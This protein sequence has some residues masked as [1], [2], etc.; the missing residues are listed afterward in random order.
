MGQSWTRK[1]H[2]KIT[3]QFWVKC[4]IGLKWS[5]WLLLLFH[6]WYFLYVYIF[7]IQHVLLKWLLF[8]QHF[9]ILNSFPPLMGYTGQGTFLLS[10]QQRDVDSLSPFP[11][12]TRSWAQGNLTSMPT[13]PY[14]FL[15]KAPPLPRPP[16]SQSWTLSISSQ[17]FPCHSN[18]NICQLCL[19]IMFSY[20]SA[21]SFCSLLG[22]LSFL[23]STCSG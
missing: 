8:H 10:P 22:S 4:L 2:T 1:S 7:Y 5:Q 14:L 19:F 13:A 23:I 3:S 6:V 16:R 18:K 17:R 9:N 21:S 15:S 20:F 11:P 12:S